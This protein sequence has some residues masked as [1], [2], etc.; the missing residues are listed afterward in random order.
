MLGTAGEEFHAQLPDV[1]RSRI[2][3]QVAVVQRRKSVVI[4][5]DGIGDFEARVNDEWITQDDFAGAGGAIGSGGLVAR[6]DV[7][8]DAP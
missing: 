5:G 8:L 2:S 4:L 6:H 3:V 7:S 1:R